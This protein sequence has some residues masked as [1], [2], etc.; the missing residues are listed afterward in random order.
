[1]NKITNYTAFFSKRSLRRKPS[2]IR[3]LQPLVRL[4]GMISLGGGMPNPQLFPIDKV[5]LT[6]KDGT[7]LAICGEDLDKALQYSPS[8]G[9]PEFTNWIKQQ[10]E[11][12]H[13]LKSSTIPDWDVLVTTGSQDGLSKT[14]DLLLNEGE[15][16][17]TEN[18]TYSGAIAAFQPIGCKLLGIKIDQHG[19]IPEELENVL[20]NWDKKES[21][22]RVIYIIP[23]GQNPSGATLTLERKTKLYQLASTHNMIIIEDDPYYY[24]QLPTVSNPI[25]QPIPSFLSMDVD[26]RV[27]RLDSFSK[28][29]SSGMR[30]GFITGPK[31]LVE[32]LQIDQQ[33]TSLHTSGL[34]Q[35]VLFSIVN[36]WGKDG[37]DKQIKA[38]EK[39][40]TERRDALISYAEKYLKGLAEWHIPAAGMFVWF[41]LLGIEDSNDLIKN[42]AV[43]EKVLLVPGKSFMPNDEPSP[44]VRAA[45]STATFEQME[46]AIKRLA[47]LLIRHKEQK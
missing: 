15:Y 11:R 1:M 34:S 18:P 5:N 36:K 17:V 27:I 19:M 23:I 41:K 6:L 39:T 9:L 8:Y 20:K 35:M 10:Q 4:P 25:V 38:V 22:P 14:F 28:I 31:Q 43:H 40:Y 13:K 2:A 3:E 16:V 44:Y 37:W 7:N 26:G 33:A 30:V 21:K 12:E 46:E 42:K 45:Y 29:A 24:I 32:Q 47:S